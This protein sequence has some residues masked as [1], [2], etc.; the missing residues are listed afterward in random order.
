MK[1]KTGSV[2]TPAPAQSNRTANHSGIGDNPRETP[3]GAGALPSPGDVP[4]DTLRETLKREFEKGLP[5]AGE[6]GPETRGRKSRLQLAAESAEAQR[7]S[8]MAASLQRGAELLVSA[9]ADVW[10]VDSKHPAVA[11]AGEATALFGQALLLKWCK[12]DFPWVEECMFGAAFASLLA[13]RY[14]TGSP[15]NVR[16]RSD[17]GQ[18]GNGKDNAA[19][20][21]FPLTPASGSVSLGSPAP[22]VGAKTPFAS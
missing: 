3:D 19:P 6:R 9:W 20:L 8:S 21:P 22:P 17:T 13:I 1:K 2:E 14:A 15:I 5:G 18:T 10:T 12:P 16:V 7:V 4:Q 11:K